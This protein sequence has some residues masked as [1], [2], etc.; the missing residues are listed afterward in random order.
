MSTDK[1]GTLSLSGGVDVPFRL[2]RSDDV[3]ALQRFHARLSETTIYL[4]FFGSLQEL[5]KEKA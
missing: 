4:R 5:P 2:I 3:P 1:H